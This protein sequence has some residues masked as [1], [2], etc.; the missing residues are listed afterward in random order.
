MQALTTKARRN[1]ASHPF[2]SKSFREQQI[3]KQHKTLEKI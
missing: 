3:T 1:C 2:S